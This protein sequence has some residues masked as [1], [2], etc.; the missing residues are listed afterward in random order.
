M[1]VQVI[2]EPNEV[3]LETTEVMSEPIQQAAVDCQAFLVKLQRKGVLL[4]TLCPRTV[5]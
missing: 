2:A 5:I 4:C 3:M 1:T